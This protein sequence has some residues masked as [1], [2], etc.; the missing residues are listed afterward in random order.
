MT[1]AARIS[2]MTTVNRLGRFG[3]PPTH[4]DGPIS[5]RQ[6]E[7]GTDDRTAEQGGGHRRGELRPGDRNG[8]A[9]DGGGER[10]Q[11]EDRRPAPDE[12]I[13]V[14]HGC[15]LYRPRLRRRLAS[16]ADLVAR[17][18]THARASST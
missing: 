10:Q 6:H 18:R 1:P 8:H 2:S 9:G 3:R 13:T 16:V 7:G 17:P 4:A 5:P 15:G 14:I 12:S 11:A